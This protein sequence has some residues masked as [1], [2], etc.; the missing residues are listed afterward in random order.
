MRKELLAA[1]G[2]G[3]LLLGIVLLLGDLTGLVFGRHGPFDLQSVEEEWDA[4]DG[5]IAVSRSEVLT[6]WGDALFIVR[7][8]DGDLPPDLRTA[9]IPD[10]LNRVA[11]TIE[12]GGDIPMIVADDVPGLDLEIVRRDGEGQEAFLIRVTPD[13]AARLHITFKAKF[14]VCPACNSVLPA[15]EFWGH[16]DELHAARATSQQAGQRTGG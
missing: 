11:R 13:D 2:A 1:L 8:F 9:P 6:F 7:S 3:L 10:S 4:P 14:P 5:T 16:Y 15:R 12:E